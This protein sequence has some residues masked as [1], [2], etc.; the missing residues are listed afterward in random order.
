MEKILRAMSRRFLL[1][2]TLA[3]FSCISISGFA[4]RGER[5]VFELFANV[6]LGLGLFLTLKNRKELLKQFTRVGCVSRVFVFIFLIYEE[7]SGLWSKGKFEYFNL[8]NMQSE[9][10]V[11]NLQ[12]MGKLIEGCRSAFYELLFQYDSFHNL[13]N[14]LASDKLRFAVPWLKGFKASFSRKRTHFMD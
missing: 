2:G 9:A 8:Y 1:L 4:T 3:V 10:N 12:F 13:F 14:R 6:V 11:H 7:M 5:N